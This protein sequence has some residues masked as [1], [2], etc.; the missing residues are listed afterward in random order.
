[1][2]AGGF[3]VLGILSAGQAQETGYD[4]V[5]RG[6]RIVDGTGNP[7]YWADLAVRGDTIAAIAPRIEGV[8]KRVIEAGGQ[9]LAPGFIDL[10]TPRV[11]AFSRCLRLTTTCG[12][13]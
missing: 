7:W 12:R 10:H 9:I 8:A 5:I 4:L 6:A 3:C 2:L 1:M 11:P 13:G